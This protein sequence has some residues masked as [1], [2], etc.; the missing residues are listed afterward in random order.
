M[1]ATISKPPAGVVTGAGGSWARDLVTFAIRAQSCVRRINVARVSTFTFDDRRLDVDAACVRRSAE[2]LPSSPRVRRSF[3]R[4]MFR[5]AP[6]SASV[7]ISALI[8][9]TVPDP[10]SNSAAIFRIPLSPLASA[11]LMLAL[12]RR[13]VGP[14]HQNLCELG[15]PLRSQFMFILPPSVPSVMTYLL[16]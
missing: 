15:P 9:W 10:T 3:A 11:F 14:V 12:A 16:V 1:K 13:R 5:V 4:V 2:G 8:R 7:A 6:K